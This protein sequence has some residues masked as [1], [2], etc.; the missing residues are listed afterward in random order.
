MVLS[1]GDQT[2]KPFEIQVESSCALHV[3]HKI[4]LLFFLL[5]INY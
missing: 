2:D 4:R 1:L 5:S 3:T